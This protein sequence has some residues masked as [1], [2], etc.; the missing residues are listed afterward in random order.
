MSV[1]DLPAPVELPDRTIAKFRVNFASISI[2]PL[3]SDGLTECGHDVVNLKE[4][5]IEADE[6][7][8]AELERIAAAKLQALESVDGMADPLPRGMVG[9]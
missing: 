7:L 5:D 4:E 3:E 1:K 9:G 6:A 8:Q 2:C